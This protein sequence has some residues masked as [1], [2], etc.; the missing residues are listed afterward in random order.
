MTLSG[1]GG[2]LVLITSFLMAA[3]L[4]CRESPTEVK[5]TSIIEV[6]PLSPGLTFQYDYQDI[7]ATS[8]MGQGDVTA[9]SGTV[10]YTIIDSAGTVGSTRRWLVLETRHLIR[11]SYIIR[12]GGERQP[13]DTLMRIEYSRQDT[14]SEDLTG[15]HNLSAS[16]LIWTFPLRDIL[17]A[18]GETVGNELQVPRFAGTQVVSSNCY[19]QVSGSNAFLTDSLWLTQVKGLSRRVMHQQAGSLYVV[20]HD[21][22]ANER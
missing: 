1:D 16:M 21:I 4:S 5:E 12:V 17:T 14:L 9:D 15:L 20:G 3:Q 13:A 22:V 6:F 2:R 7:T 8:D 10:S 11:L 19:L 18:Q